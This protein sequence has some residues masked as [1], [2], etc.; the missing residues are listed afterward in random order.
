MEE[1]EEGPRSFTRFLETLADGDAVA[2]LNE[3][4]HRL[5]SHLMHEANA[6]GAGVKGDLTLKVSFK[7]EPHGVVAILYSVKMK[8]PEPRRAGSIAWLTEGGNFTA[9]NPRQQKLPLVEVS[10][11]KKAPVNLG[12]EAAND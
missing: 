6:R 8:E 5:G 4:L 12:E 9:Q 2:E 10:A 3:K 11:P 1:H 7:V